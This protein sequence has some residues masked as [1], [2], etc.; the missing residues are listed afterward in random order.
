MPSR[1]PALYL[2]DIV[3]SAR[4]VESFLG[5]R[6]VDAF[7]SEDQ[8]ASAVHSKLIIIGEAAANLPMEIRDAVPDVDWQA[9]VRF[10]NLVVHAYFVMNLD[11][12]Y[13][14]AR[15]D[16]PRL[17]ASV[18]DYLRREHPLVAQALE[19]GEA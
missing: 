14:I 6:S 7:R 13:S 9:L 11:R 19:Q 3:T 12:V 16:V 17:A 5:D 1:D 2:A 15:Q 4:A 18:L 8:L 10:R